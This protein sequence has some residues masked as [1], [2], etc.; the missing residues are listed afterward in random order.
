MST[1]INTRGMVRSK[2]A[3]FPAGNDNECL[4][5]AEILS[6]GVAK[7][8]GSYGSYECVMIDDVMNSK[9][10]NFIYSRYL[11]H[12]D[13]DFGVYIDSSSP[14][15]SQIQGTVYIIDSWGSFERDFTLNVGEDYVG[16]GKG[17]DEVYEVTCSGSPSEDAFYRYV[18]R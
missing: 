11:I 9:P 1:E 15:T 5:Q 17:P 10:I 6:S 4:S 12:D 7:V 18:Y 3:N 14:V 8:N 2:V 13:G 16:I